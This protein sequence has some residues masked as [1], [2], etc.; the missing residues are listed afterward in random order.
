V[1]KARRAQF[2]WHVGDDDDDDKS[3]TIASVERQHYRFRPSWLP[4]RVQRAILVVMLVTACSVAL[5]V[6]LH[7]RRAQDRLRFQ[8]QSV[9][10]LEA[11][12]FV[13]GDVDLFLAQQDRD[14]AE[15][16]EFQSFL[17]EAA[18]HWPGGPDAFPLGALPAEIQRVELHGDSAWVEVVEGTPAVRRMRFYRQTGQGWLHT[19]PDLAFWGD[20]VWLNLGDRLAIH[21]Y[22]RDWPYVAPLV[23]QLEQDLAQVCATVGCSPRLKLMVDICVNETH[24]SIALQ[25]PWL[26]GIPVDSSPWSSS[27]YILEDPPRSVR[28]T[29]LRGLVDRIVSERFRAK[30][31]WENTPLRTIKDEYVIWL[32]DRDPT[33][34]PLLG[35][36]V[37]EH[38]ED[39]LPG[40]FDSLSRR[41]SMS[42]FLSEW[43]GLTP[44]EQREPFPSRDNALSKGL[45]YARRAGLVGEPT[46]VTIAKMDYP[47]YRSLVDRPGTRLS[48]A[49]SRV[50]RQLW[51]LGFR[52]KVVLRLP[53]ADG[54]QYRYLLI[55]LDAQ[56]GDEL[57]LS[58]YPPGQEPDFQGEQL[59]LAD[60][61]RF[62]I[63]AED[64]ALP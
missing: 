44:E 35:R 43:L 18:P 45:E 7:Y 59:I 60:G 63:G 37:A 34:A 29:V 15:W 41:P 26:S 24:S 46:F 25:S 13:E 5:A 2:V 8:I 55:A 14:A 21:Y 61:A 38:G 11:R 51:V 19:A 33:R 1:S 54:G 57:S 50:D 32:H 56:T 31:Y 3:E 17:M 20:E 53:G 58:A 36:I 12:T 28:Q 48:G 49:G 22:E 39:T 23:D 9:I 16:Y 62:P 52:G 42:E 4:T 47:Q 64:A 40:V 27:V 30:Q 10:D 6:Y